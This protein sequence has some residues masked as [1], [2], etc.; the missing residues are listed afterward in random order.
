VEPR[1]LRV[2]CV[3]DH[4]PGGAS[5]AEV[6]LQ[7][8]VEGLR[9]AGDE[10]AVFHRSPHTGLGRL[11][12][13]WDPVARRALARQVAA[14]G[15]DVLHF[16]NVVR[17]LSVAVL[18]AAAGTPR[19]LTVHD[20][21]LLG[22]ADAQGGLLRGWQRRRAAVD[23]AVARRHGGEV[24]AVSGPLQS[25]LRS[26][27]FPQATTAWP[28]AAAPVRPLTDPTA[29]RDLAFVGRLDPD[30]GVHL[31]VEAFLAA[32]R[33]GARLLLAGTGSLRPATHDGRVVLLG[34]LARHEVSELL[35]SVRAVVLPS[36][37]ARR[38]EGAPLALVE[39]LVHGRPLLVS[40][41][42]GSVEV[43]RGGA[44]RPAGLVVPAGDRAALTAALGR[45]LDDDALVARLAQG[46]REAAPAH[47]PAAGL[48]RVRAAYARAVG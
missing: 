23:R 48:A 13:A 5:G 35:G 7:L 12:D 39:A 36:L 11:A 29:S 15:P 28:W 27:G 8:L 3:N 2:L 41:D 37:P 1:P 42:P 25:R 32:D 45:L 24:L 19:V 26:A 38:P 17:E 6:H 43:A 22:D 46:A 10:V 44:P 14:F 21:R 18:T 47:L 30:K 31:L 4:P 20:G 34:R 16:H 9:A 40:D 33:P